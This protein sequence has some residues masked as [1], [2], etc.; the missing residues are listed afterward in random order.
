M[1]ILAKV[2]P[3]KV[4]IFNVHLASKRKGNAY[5][6]SVSH[7]SLGEIIMGMFLKVVILH[8]QLLKGY[9]VF[10]TVF[11][12]LRQKTLGSLFSN[13]FTLRPFGRK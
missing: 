6:P 10:P 11:A 7:T 8:L 9:Y 3:Y 12:Y 1:Y 4:G 2:G 5:I 13:N